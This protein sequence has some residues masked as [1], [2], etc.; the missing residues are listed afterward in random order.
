MFW[1]MK[2]SSAA[3]CS[4]SFSLPSSWLSRSSTYSVKTSL[5]TN[6]FALPEMGRGK[7]NTNTA[8]KKICTGALMILNPVFLVM[9]NDKFPQH[10]EIAELRSVIVSNV[11]PKMGKP[12]Q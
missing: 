4:S 11:A 2:F 8:N 6:N 10:L 12:G 5:V 3:C 7:F 9:G 1:R